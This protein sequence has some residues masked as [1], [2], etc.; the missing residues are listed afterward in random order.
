MAEPRGIIAAAMVAPA[1][2]ATIIDEYRIVINAGRAAGV[3][4]GQ[5]FLI[6]KIG[7][8]VFDPDTKLSLG[9]VEIIKGKGEVIH[10]QESMA[11]LQTTEKHEIKRLPAGLLGLSL[12][13]SF[14]VTREP[15]AFINPEV[16]D[17]AR[18]LA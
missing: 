9:R 4:I 10:V 8:E 7:D 15:K 18:L 14:E 12:A 11:T 5:Q 2:I 6:Y 13:A 1:K 3:K 17:F 16:G